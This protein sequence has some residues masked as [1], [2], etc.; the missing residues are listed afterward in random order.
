E[1][2]KRGPQRGEPPGGAQTA[3]FEPAN[4][5][6]EAFVTIVTT[7]DGPDLYKIARERLAAAE[8]SGF[9]GLVQ[10]NAD[11][12]GYFY[13]KRETG[14]VFTGVTGTACTE[15]IMEIYQQSWADSHGGGTK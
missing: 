8:A 7:M 12:S 14:R 9:E 4:A 6:I 15:N 13:D 10:K 1:K 5:K 3:I 2:N 11:W